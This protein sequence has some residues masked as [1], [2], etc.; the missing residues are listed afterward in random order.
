MFQSLIREQGVPCEKL[1]KSTNAI[2]IRIAP[3]LRNFKAGYNVND[4]VNCGDMNTLIVFD[5]GISDPKILNY[6][7]QKN[8]DKR[9]IFY[10]W[11][12][13]GVSFPAEKIP[14]EYEKW[15]YSPS[16]CEKY[17][18]KYNS[19]FYF[20]ELVAPFE[21]EGSF[22]ISFIGKDKGRYPTLMRYQELFKASGLT[23]DFYITAT[24]PKIDRSK[25]RSMSYPESLR[26]MQKSRCIF[27]YYNDPEAGLSLRMMEAMYFGKKIITNNRRAKEYEF[28]KEE[29]VLVLENEFDTK[30]FSAFLNAPLQ[31][32][33]NEEK[34][35]YSFSRWLKR[36]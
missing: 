30:D 3:L 27:D 31:E 11:N 24:H 32:I 21:P 5:S 19:T 20:P 33:P 18:L 23:T 12:P 2:T 8:R 4:A 36:F 22:D 35:Y 14:S 1:L 29:N 26:R 7:A 34:E 15:S 6:I 13:V 25:P 9:L 28:F 16:D 10:Y 17:G